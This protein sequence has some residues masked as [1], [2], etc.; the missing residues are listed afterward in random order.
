MPTDPNVTRSDALTRL[1]LRD[2]ISRWCWIVG[3]PPAAMLESR[4]EMIRIL[5]ASA[6]IACSEHLKGLCRANRPRRPI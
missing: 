4:S 6:P 5:V 3:E 1:P 2:F